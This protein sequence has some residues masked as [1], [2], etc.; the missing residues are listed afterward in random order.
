MA[1]PTAF[2]AAT[3]GL[4][5][6]LAA[7][8][9][10]HKQDPTPSLT[11]PSGLGTTITVAVSPDVLTQDGASQSLVSITALD[12][13]GQPIRNLSLR[14]D[15]TVNGQIADFGS[16]SAHNVVTDGN[17]RATVVYTAPAA[18]AFSV[19]NGTMVAISAT[20]SGTDFNNAVAIHT[21]SIRLVPPGTIG[22]GTSPIRP[23]FLL[24]TANI[25]DSAVFTATV[26]DASGND[27]TTQVTGYQWTFGDGGTASGKTVTHTY[28]KPGAFPVTVT[29]TDTLGR[30][31]SQVHTL[32]VGQPATGLSAGFVFSP[33]QPV[34]GQPVHFD[35]STSIV[36]QP[37]RIVSYAWNWGDGGFETTAN[38]RIDHQY[39]IANVYTVVLT[40][41]D[42]TGQTKTTSQTV[43]VK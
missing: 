10:L 4:L 7:G 16:L 33:T 28:T 26:T 3:A 9:T 6:T 12:S 32:T 20:P 5:L 11:G 2:I 38:A 27:A 39:Q 31:A 19:D 21:A 29:I 37:H 25:G 36:N 8:C 42:D 30:M 24:P 40:V 41:T 17:G 22:V 1:R 18:P 13:T 35:A 34:N 15:I 23:E 14:A 43:T